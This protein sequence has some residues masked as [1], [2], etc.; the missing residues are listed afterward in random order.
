[1]KVGLVVVCQS[2]S[3]VVRY[4]L[5]PSLP[6]VPRRQKLRLG[7]VPSGVVVLRQEPC[8]HEPVERLRV[9]WMYLMYA[10]VAAEDQE[11][12]EALEHVVD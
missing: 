12:V 9:R 11:I 8:L 10:E 6:S 3:V 1:M 7:S 2:Q 4:W 5:R